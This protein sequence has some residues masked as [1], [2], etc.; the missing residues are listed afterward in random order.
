VES[1]GQTVNWI[2]LEEI[3][4]IRILKAL[5]LA[6]NKKSIPE[7]ARETGIPSSSLYSIKAHGPYEHRNRRRR[8]VRVPSD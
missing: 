6:M 3:G 1:K 4:E 5:Q 2:A 8:S 7:I